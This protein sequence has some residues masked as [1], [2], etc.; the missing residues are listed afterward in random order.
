MA[1]GRLAQW[2]VANGSTVKM[3]QP[4]FEF[5]TDKITT[6][7]NAPSGGV[8]TFSVEAGSVIVPGQE[9]ASIDPAGTPSAAAAP[10]PMS[11]CL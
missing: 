1:E 4:L 9:V 6:P 5:E 11:P 7:V 2:L 10:V 3:N 8:V